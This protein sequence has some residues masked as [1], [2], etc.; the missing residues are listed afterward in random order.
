MFHSRRQG[1]MGFSGIPR[2]RAFFV[3][4]PTGHERELRAETGN[5]DSSPHQSREQDLYKLATSCLAFDTNVARDPENV[6]NGI[7]DCSAN[8]PGPGFRVGNM[9]QITQPIFTFKCITGNLSRCTLGTAQPMFIAGLMFGFE[10]ACLGTMSWNHCT[11]VLW[12]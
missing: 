2:T 3:T 8:Q 12:S 10:Y 7:A 1:L 11:T 4:F 9:V 5:P 6:Q